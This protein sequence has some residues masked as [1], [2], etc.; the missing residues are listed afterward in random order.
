MSTQEEIESWNSIMSGIKEIQE[1]FPE[2]VVFIG[3]V[4]V[5]MHSTNN[6]DVKTE[7]SHDAV[8]LFPWQI[9]PIFEISRK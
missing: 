6:K 7:F 1:W 2:D 4:A 8:F 3:G 9:M 5:F